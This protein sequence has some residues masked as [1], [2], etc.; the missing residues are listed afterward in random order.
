MLLV[1]LPPRKLQGLRSIQSL[2]CPSL[3]PFLA[4]HSLPVH[5]LALGE[6]GSGGGGE[7]QDQERKIA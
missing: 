1:L 4:Q 6:V 5:N 3:P 2:L 7:D